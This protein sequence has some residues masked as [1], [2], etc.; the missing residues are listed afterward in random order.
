MDISDSQGTARV[1][2]RASARVLII[3]PAY[4]EA[5]TISAVIERLHEAAPECDIVVIDDGS[6]DETA[7]VVES[8][9]DVELVRLPFNLGIGG[10]MQTGYKYAL[11]AGYD[12]AVQCDADGQHPVD[13]IKDLV[14]HVDGGKADLIIGSRYV[15]ETSYK[16]SMGRRVGKSI[17]SRLVDAVLG[18]GI[19]D[20]TSGFRAANRKVMA[21]FAEHYPEDYPEPETLVILHKCGLSAAEIPVEMLPRQ[22][23]VTSIS[24]PNAIYYMIKV[25]LAIFMNVVRTFPG[26][27][28][29][30]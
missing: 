19:T 6:T 10:A 13:R 9:A 21:L 28:G 11:R 12:I 22:G 26:V 27:P 4:N 18:R 3:I 1:N 5:A 14:A 25:A 24:S 17:L 8:L 7:T 2:A 30:R 23:G 15:A 16:P 20:T 29:G